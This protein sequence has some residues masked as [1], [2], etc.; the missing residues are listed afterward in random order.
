MSAEPA[1]AY[2]CLMKY[3]IIALLGLVIV[4]C[5]QPVKPKAPD[6]LTK[7]EMPAPVQQLFS[8]VAAN[9]DSIGLRLQLV[10]SLDSLGA[11]EQALGQMDSLIKKD[12]LNYGLW[13]RKALLQESTKD[14][15]GALKSYR[16]AIRIYPSPDAQLA[17]ANLLAE[18]KDSTALLLCKQ[19]ASFNMGREYNAH[20]HFI[21]GVYFA[22]TGN[23][24]KA[25]QAFNNC[26]IND[27]NYT[28]AYMEKG[29]LFYDDKKYT[30]ALQVYQTLV[31]IKNTYADGYYWL[32]KTEEALNNKTE[33]ISNY[34][35]SLVLDPTLKEASASLQRLGAK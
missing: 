18:R 10:N 28:E 27:L 26:I 20:C 32:A 3:W 24:Q 16:Y 5:N 19:V 4:A 1:S 23:K 17:A 9:P 12:S 33:A 14:T 22:R 25:L 30:E 6:T 11:Y 2:F 35:K 13:Y 7:D 34:Q 21:T 29:F 31:T 8:K 15:T